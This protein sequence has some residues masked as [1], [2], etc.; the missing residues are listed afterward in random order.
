MSTVSYVNHPPIPPSIQAL[1]QRPEIHS[2]HAGP[3]RIARSAIDSQAPDRAREA[4]LDSLQSDYLD[5]ALSAKGYKLAEAAIPPAK[6]GAPGVQVSTFAVDGAQSSDI[7][8]VKRVPVTP[9]GPNF[10]LYVPHEDEASFHEFTTAEDMTTWLKEMAT[11]P[12]QLDAFARHFSLAAAPGQVERVKETL[13][14]FAAD[15]I[16]AV[17]GSF[18]YEKGDIFQ[19][20]DKDATVPPVQVNGLSQTRLFSI[21]PDGKA[22]YIGTRPDGKEVL[23]S[24][25][26]YGNLHGGN[27]NDFYLVRNGLNNDEPLTPMTLKQYTRKVAN[28]A[29]D[30]VGANDLRGLYDEFLKQLRNPGHGLGTALKVLGVPEDVANSIETI[31]KNPVKGTLLELN[32]DNRLGKLFGVERE[33]M[34]S[35]LEKVGDE[36]QSLIPVYGQRRAQL[37]EA[38]DLLEERFGTPEEPKAQVVAR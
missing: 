6:K 27:K 32:H 28:V 24:Y 22:T 25:D 18:A 10:L 21:K 36:L 35:A 37:E 30:N 11:D 23:F 12:E 26:A 34:D 13:V 5:G 1:I 7:V 3:T 4:Y 31:V 8:V 16:N 19:R 38:A 29:L 17:V 2:E 14:R 20:L 15:D 9:E 33:A